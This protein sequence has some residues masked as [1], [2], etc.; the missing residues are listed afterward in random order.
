MCWAALN[1]YM[2][3]WTVLIS[4]LNS[5]S[6]RD[7][8]CMERTGREH[9]Q[10][11]DKLIDSYP[12]RTSHQY[13]QTLSTWLDHEYTQATA[14]PLR[15]T[16][17][18]SHAQ[19]TTSD[20][21]SDQLTVYRMWQK[22]SHRTKSLWE[23][24]GAGWKLHFTVKMSQ[25]NHWQSD[26][27]LVIRPNL[28]RNCQGV[29]GR[30]CF[31]DSTVQRVSNSS[32]TFRWIYNCINDCN[33]ARER[34][35]VSPVFRI[36]LTFKHLAPSLN[37]RNQVQSCQTKSSHGSWHWRHV[38]N[39]QRRRSGEVHTECPSAQ[40]LVSSHLLQTT[41]LGSALVSNYWTTLDLYQ[42]CQSPT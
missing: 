32:P 12:T 5:V 34:P 36:P 28:Y 8:L 13:L 9:V 40:R 3:V 7:S 16:A 24:N 31:S 42:E 14:I 23:F 1:R 33:G 20:T 21:D 30:N 4:R 15:N 27:G 2:S 26:A 29:E 10:G 39:L 41:S 35:P 18:W 37:N 22:F 19:L 11:R 25:N 38:T 17:D 6:D